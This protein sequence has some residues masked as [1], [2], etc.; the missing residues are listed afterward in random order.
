MK[1]IYLF[2]IL[3]LSSC[4]GTKK[5]YKAFSSR[6]KTK[7]PD[8]KEFVLS[9]TEEV[10]RRKIVQSNPLIIIDFIALYDKE[11]EEE[12]YAMLYREDIGAID[13]LNGEKAIPI[14]GDRGKNGLIIVTRNVEKQKYLKHYL[15]RA[16]RLASR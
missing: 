4:I 16:K 13:A 8:G 5:E 12:Q 3:L 11:I 14:Y 9:T 6:M 1:Y 7:Q 10:I 2:L 15:K